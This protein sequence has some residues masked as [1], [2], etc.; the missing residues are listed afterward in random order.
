MEESRYLPTDT[1]GYDRVVQAQRLKRSEKNLLVSFSQT[2]I[3]KMCR[4]FDMRIVFRARLPGHNNVFP[5]EFSQFWNSVDSKATG[6]FL[7]LPS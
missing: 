5:L 2:V 6:R 1:L 3:L 7:V 4:Y